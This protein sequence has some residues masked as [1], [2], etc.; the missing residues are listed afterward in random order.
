MEADGYG[1]DTLVQPPTFVDEL[2]SVSGDGG[3][4]RETCVAT[5]G[6]WVL[7]DGF[8]DCSLVGRVPPTGQRSRRS[9]RFA[10]SGA[11]SLL[12]SRLIRTWA[13]CGCSQEHESRERSRR[14]TLRTGGVGLWL[15]SPGLNP[16][17]LSRSAFSRFHL[18]AVRILGTEEQHRCGSWAALGTWGWLRTVASTATARCEDTSGDFQSQAH[19]P[20]LAGSCLG[21]ASRRRC[22]GFGFP[23]VGELED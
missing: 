6:C 2:R 9:I 15:P 8:A 3:S 23:S 20:A 4:A 5:S 1:R 21:S 12:I 19:L 11:Q 22:A 10:K 14:T 17:P 7:G 18:S 16:P 13:G